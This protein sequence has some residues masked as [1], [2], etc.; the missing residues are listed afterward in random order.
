MFTGH[1]EVPESL[2]KGSGD[3]A[4]I[5]CT[6]V[7]CTL[8]RHAVVMHNTP[9]RHAVVMHNTPPR[10]AV[11]MHNSLPRHDLLLKKTPCDA[12]E[13]CHVQCLRRVNL[14]CYIYARVYKKGLVQLQAWVSGNV[15][16]KDCMI[17]LYLGYRILMKY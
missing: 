7:P 3:V 13:C 17:N 15:L 4:L 6:V 11:V 14:L 5:G 9:P 2:G 1:L 10:H 12:V 8:P 16:L